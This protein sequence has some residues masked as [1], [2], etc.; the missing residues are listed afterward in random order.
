[1]VRWVVGSILHG[2]DPLSYFSFQPVF[3]DWCN[4]AFVTSVVEHWLER[5][6]AQWVHTM[7]DRSD[8]QSH[9]ER[10]LLPRSYISLPQFVT[11][12][13]DKTANNLTIICKHHYI[14]YP[15]VCEAP[16]CV[17]KWKLKFKSIN[18][19]YKYRITWQTILPTI[20]L[21][22]ILERWHDVILL[23]PPIRVNYPIKSNI[24]RFICILIPLPCKRF[25]VPFRCNTTPSASNCDMPAFRTSAKQ[26]GNVSIIR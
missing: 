23:A 10:T 20:C 13:T 4:S 9:H 17:L 26:K 22:V 5:E 11:V 8:D 3:H 7:K 12:P 1:M 14:N 19:S 6:I 2:V 16:I 15:N 21:V 25:H 18:E 24:N